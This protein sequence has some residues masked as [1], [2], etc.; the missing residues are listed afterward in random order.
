MR[1]IGKIITILIIGSNIVLGVNVPNSSTIN[2]Q[3]HAPK[4]IPNQK[5]EDINIQAVPNDNVKVINSTKVV[6][7]SDFTFSGNSTVSSDELKATLKDYVAKELTFNQIQELLAIITKVYRDKRYLVARAYLEKQDLVRNNNVL[8]ISI[9]EGKLDEVKLSNNSLVKDNSL[10]AILN[11]VKSNE[12]LE[13]EDI[14]RA[15]LLIND[16]AGV[17]VR[18]SSLEAGE[19]LGSSNLN[20]ETVATSRVD[21]YVV[22][23]NYGSRYT[24]EN[25]IQALANI[26]SPLGI[27]DK[28]IISGLISNGAN[29]KNTKLSYEVFLNTTGLKADF[30][31]SKTNYKLVEEYENLDATG[32]SNIYEI[33]LSYP[34]ILSSDESLW[35][36]IKYFYKDMSDYMSDVKYENKTINLQVVTL[37]YEKEYFLG[38]F[39]SRLFTNLNLTMG[40]L[41]NELNTDDG[42]YNKIDTYVSNEIAFN[43]IIS[44]NTNLTAQKVLGNKN[45]DGNEDLSLGGVYG[46]KLYPNSQQNAENGYILNLEFLSKLPSVFSYT[47]K[48]GLFYDI[49]DV[50]IENQDRDV[51]FERE[52]LKDIG[53]GYYSNYKDFF[54]RT[55]MAWSANS[56]EITSEN[57]AHKN[58]KFLIQAG[59]IF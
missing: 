19:N 20:I 55:Q 13:V 49:G 18:N 27:G 28:I 11:N 29:L 39:P 4:D 8:K 40:K 41:N 32:N 7:I 42:R 48:V 2:R 21:G 15:L 36:R 47:H 51:T 59:M 17:K 35:T 38:N 3:I 30:A 23:D 56:S 25:R 26:N 16:R 22:A 46:V 37:D 14:Q 50:Y 12:I 5:K 58:S 53:V 34:L 31:Y 9:I 45:L 24:G 44:L 1:K 54:L 57:S 43:E 52:R 6:L 33:G 10:G